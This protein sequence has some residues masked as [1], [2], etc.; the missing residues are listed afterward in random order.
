[1]ALA[2]NDPGNRVDK[3]MYLR[4]CI[5]IEFLLPIVLG[6]Y[7][8]TALRGNSGT[9]QIAGQGLEFKLLRG[10]RCDTSCTLARPIR[11]PHRMFKNC[12]ELAIDAVH[13]A[14]GVRI[15][16]G[17]V[18]PRQRGADAFQP[19]LACQWFLRRPAQSLVDRDDFFRGIAQ[20]GIDLLQQVLLRAGVQKDLLALLAPLHDERHQQR[21][22]LRRHAAACEPMRGLD[23]FKD[24]RTL[25]IDE[26]HDMA[27]LVALDL[28]D[29]CEAHAVQH[30][31]N[32][33]ES[34]IARNS[35]GKGVAD[36][37]IRLVGTAACDVMLVGAEAGGGLRHECGYRG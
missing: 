3:S 27:C 34:A 37:R 12:Q 32:Q 36:A 1:M 23:Q 35:H 25:G 14:H 17:M 19:S 5:K 33:Q 21:G 7:P 29:G 9:I 16:C 8:A 20:Q 2:G 24:V 26:K 22:A 28:H 11:R 4:I 15:P 31:L 6:D 13:H 18:E 10:S 30:V